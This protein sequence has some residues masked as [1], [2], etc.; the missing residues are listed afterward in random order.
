M[1]KS[2]PSPETFPPGSRR[3][4][5]SQP[6]QRDNVV[7]EFVSLEQD[8]SSTFCGSFLIYSP[9]AAEYIWQDIGD[10]SICFPVFLLSSTLQHAV[11]NGEY[12]VF[13]LCKWAIYFTYQDTQ[14]FFVIRN[15]CCSILLGKDN[16]YFCCFQK[17]KMI[18]S[19]L[20]NKTMTVIIF[21][22]IFV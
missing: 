15:H 1:S 18:N 10:L 8:S 3:L 9:A 13:V 19:W 7:I 21:Y 17:F 22:G 14:T 5:G 6:R 4:L 16:A 11:V 2:R 12:N 20:R